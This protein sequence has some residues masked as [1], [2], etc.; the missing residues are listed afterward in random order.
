MGCFNNVSYLFYRKIFITYAEHPISDMSKFRVEISKR[1]IVF[2][3]FCP[4]PV[5]F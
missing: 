1:Y 4:N 3:D 5:F 2:G